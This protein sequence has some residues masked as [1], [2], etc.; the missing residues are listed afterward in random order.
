MTACTCCGNALEAARRTTCRPC[1]DWIRDHLNEVEHL[2]QQLPANLE[3]GRG[4]QG[5]RVSGGGGAAAIPLAEDV[6]N[7][8]VG[9]D[10][11]PARLAR[12]D[13]AIRAARG[14]SP[15]GER[16]STD[17][18][19]AAAV[20]SL[21]R[22]LPWTVEHHDTYE[23]AVEL[24]ALVG[25]MLAAVGERSDTL[26]LG[27]NCPVQLEDGT[28]CGGGLRYNRVTRTIRCGACGARQD[29]LA[30]IAPPAARRTAA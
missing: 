17:G 22:N 23:L 25:E 20:G 10:G 3:R 7:L 14:L 30:W 13:T 28:E 12:H 8:M 1:E 26:A 11:V 16:G 27:T 4:A 29:P 6:L 5:P 9:A 2:W 19:L 21:R 15:L 24:R 18:R